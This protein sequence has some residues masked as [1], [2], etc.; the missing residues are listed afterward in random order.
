MLGLVAEENF[1]IGRLINDII[2]VGS[3]CCERDAIGFDEIM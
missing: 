1:T 3:T 2:A